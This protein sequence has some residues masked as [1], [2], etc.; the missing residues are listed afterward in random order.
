MPLLAT[1]INYFFVCKRK[2]WLFSNGIN[3]EH[4]S[5]TVYDGK[6][7]HEN[8]YPQRAQKHNEM[9]LSAQYGDIELTGKIDFYD[10]ATKT[11]H[12]TKRSDKV[13]TAHEWQAKFYIWLLELNGISDATATLEYPKLR[14]TNQV[15]FTETDRQRLQA[16]VHEIREM[17]A[18]ENCPPRIN[19]KICKSCSYFELCYVGE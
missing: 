8:S 5:D 4:T 9:E 13:E 2:L 7:L 18:S 15:Q 11:I 10:A 14:Q 3:M 17:I 19:S 16:L 1:H 12:E 6:M